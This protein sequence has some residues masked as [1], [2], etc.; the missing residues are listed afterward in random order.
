L[1]NFWI[2]IETRLDTRQWWGR[3]WRGITIT[4]VRRREGNRTWS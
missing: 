1:I 4:R 2:E 3:I